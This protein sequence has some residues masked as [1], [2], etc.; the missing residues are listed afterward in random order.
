MAR[1][2]QP[3]RRGKTV[4]QAPRASR[5]SRAR[6]ERPEWERVVW[7]FFALYLVL[8]NVKLFGEARPL[9]RE[10]RITVPLSL[11][12]PTSCTV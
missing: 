5:V 9:P 3:G 2:E 8:R 10:S 4:S 12:P 1:S 6:S 11:L 7:A